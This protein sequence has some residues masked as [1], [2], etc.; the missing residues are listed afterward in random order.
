ML[1]KGKAA[2]G[3]SPMTHGREVCVGVIA[4]GVA[5]LLVLGSGNAVAAPPTIVT[6]RVVT[7]GTTSAILEAEAT[8]GGKE[9]ELHFEYD[10]TEYKEGEGPHGTSTPTQKLHAPE[11]PK[12]VEAMIKGLEPGTTYHFRAVASN[13]SG[14]AAGADRTFTTYALPLGALPDE[15]AYEQASPVDKN[16]GDAIGLVPF[17]K[18]AFS[19]NGITY[20]S[21]S[22]IPGG[23][24]A[25][26]LPLYLASRAGEGP[27]AQWQTQG[28]L[29]PESLGPKARV[30]G[31][32]PDFTR[33]YQQAT[34]FGAANTRAVF[35]RRQ[36]V[37]RS[38]QPLT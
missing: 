38:K 18:A 23:V 36:A 20:G 16:G 24:G 13:P 10:T 6:K 8:T 19:G 29:P 37:K 21:T 31:W 9:T 26:E 35:E 28:L 4:L 17:V 2:R 1:G 14:K 33:V 7:V 27:E 3:Q 22:G 32:T 11:S 5:F 34:H 12:T 25:Q 15:R 30:I